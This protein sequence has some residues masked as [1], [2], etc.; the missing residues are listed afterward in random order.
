MERIHNWTTRMGNA[1]RHGLSGETCKLPLELAWKYNYG[2]YVWTGPVIEGERVYCTGT[3]AIALDLRTGQLLWENPTVRSFGYASAAV[4]PDALYI[5][6]TAG[7]FALNKNTGEIIFHVEANM[8]NSSPCIDGSTVFF[9]GEKEKRYYLFAVD[10]TT[11]KEKWKFEGNKGLHQTPSVYE[12]LV[13]FG[14]G[15]TVRALDINSGTLRW[16]HTFDAIKVRDTILVFDGKVFV[17][18]Q[19]KALYA[20][21]AHSGDIRWTFEYKLGSHCSPCLSSGK[22]FLI[23]ATKKLHA[24]DITTGKEIWQSK[25]FGFHE[26][27]PISVGDLIFIGGGHYN[28]VYGFHQSNGDKVWEF[29]TDDIIFS[30]PAFANSSLVIGSHDGYIYCFRSSDLGT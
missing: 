17:S 24:L 2:V 4:G 30:S 25:E 3:R 26:T 12:G 28:Y 29:P 19:D 21:D 13:I 20:M 5:C 27:N 9:L 22:E 11:G 18:V 10:T 8:L 23:I 6:A 15:P 14:N 1:Q 16:S 7:L